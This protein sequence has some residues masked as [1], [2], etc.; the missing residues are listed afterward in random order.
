MALFQK[1][2]LM[3]A[4]N[5]LS[6]PDQL[7]FLKRLARLMELGYP[8]IQALET[9]QADEQFRSMT[10]RIKLTL[11]NGGTLD[12]ALVNE[13]FPGLVTSF[14]FFARNGGRLVESI[15]K[16]SVLYEHQLAQQKTLRST[17]RYPLILLVSFLILFF[18]IK[19]FLLPSFTQIFETASDS[20]AAQY[21]LFVINALSYGLIGIMVCASGVF[22]VWRVLI[23]RLHIKQQLNLI[24]RIPGYR[25]YVRMQT[26]F[27]FAS[28]VGSLLESG[29]PIKDVFQIIASQKQLP[30]LSH[31]S[32]KMTRELTKGVLPSEIL[33]Q[34]PFIY[35]NLA[36]LFQKNVDSETLVKDLAVYA[37]FLTEDMHR[38]T[39][40][41]I[42]MIQPAVFLMLACFIILTY[43]AL[44]APMLD[45]IK[46]I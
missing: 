22:I 41:M 46:T 20:S 24:R 18:F 11:K 31:Y 23:P 6:P 2:F 42:A 30:I 16:G 45:L 14:V 37:E 34:M 32:V 4:K 25:N 1:L 3:K 33:K 26:S 35:H 38:K 21:A 10:I 15:Q 43:V 17:S 27:N 44:M 28:H 12:Q 5:R 8:L 40:R 19:R 29:L 9:L 13:R 36:V 7:R 39:I